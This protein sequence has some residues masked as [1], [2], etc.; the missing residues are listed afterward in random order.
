MIIALDTETT[1]VLWQDD[2][3]CVTLSWRMANGTIVSYFYDLR[4]EN[5]Y[6]FLTEKFD[7]WTEDEAPPLTV[8]C[9]NLKFDLQKILKAGI[10]NESHTKKIQ[11][12]DTM[13][14]SHLI[15]ENRSRRLKDL[16]KEVLGETTD[17]AESIRKAKR[18]LKLK[19]EDGYDKL[20][21]EIVK[22]YALKDAEFTL[23]LYERFQKELPEDLL[24][25]Y[26]HEVDLTMALLDVEAK[27]LAVDLGYAKD[28]KREYGSKIL[29]AKQKIRIITGLRV[30]DDS[31]LI[32]Q[33][34]EKPVVLKN[35]KVRE[36][37]TKAEAK[38]RCDATTFNPNSTV[39]LRAVFARRGI[40]L[41][42]TDKQ[43]LLNLNDP[44]AD[45]ILELREAMKIR[46][47]YFLGILYEHDD[48]ILHGNYRQNVS[49]GRM[50]SLKGE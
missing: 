46:Q 27:G 3:F 20:P 14:M 38:R 45:A 4:D 25:L 7:Y 34:L 8:I 12:E 41:E 36:W 18:D 29:K 9:H 19:A 11:W 16:A 1:G 43:S 10:I 50:S 24:P 47:T 35:G 2:A 37:E 26:R 21:I 28:M 49:S 33:L 13:L 32:P 22:P 17:E 23:R 15:D 31:M 44:L 6:R 42:S 39:Q 5:E 48:G 30:F 40:N